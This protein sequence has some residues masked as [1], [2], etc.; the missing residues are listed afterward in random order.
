MIHQ[1]EF[2]PWT[3][4]F[5]K[6]AACDVFVFLDDVQYLR[7][8]YQ[9]RNCI[10]NRDGQQWLTVPLRRAP[11]EQ[12]I[13]DMEIDVS[14]NWQQSHMSA[15]K[16]A[17]KPAPYY[18]E[19]WPILE[20]GYQ[21]QWASLSELDCFLT[22]HI[23]HALDFHPEF[24]RA[25]ELNAQ[26][27]KAERIMNICLALKATRYI[28]GLGGKTYLDEKE[29]QKH[30]VEIAY[31][32]PFEA[33]YQQLYPEKGFAAGLSIVDYLFNCGIAGVRQELMSLAQHQPYISD[34]K[35]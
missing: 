16:S 17:Y 14:K 24:V 29:F 19:V 28:S 2:L 25:S 31:I 15:L 7:R 3:G 12:S 10:K 30:D 5:V 11:R 35:N 33:R 20:P 22:I 23:A 34:K 1:P 9:N 21:K 26:G 13:M 8:S 4:L 18:K 6:M 32:P 27:V